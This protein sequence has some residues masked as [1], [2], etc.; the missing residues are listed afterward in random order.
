VFTDDTVRPEAAALL[1]P[2][3]ELRV[4]AAYPSE[5]TLALACRD[6]QGILARLGTVTRRVIEQAPRLKIIARH[7][8]GVDAVDLAAATAHG[9]V[10]TTTGAQ[11]AAAVAE[12]TVALMLAVLRHVPRAD[13]EM[14]SGAWARNALVGG[15]LDGRTLGVVG[16]GAIGRRVARAGCGF[17]MRVLAFDPALG[18][19][20]D[21]DA[22]LVG[23]ERLLA[24]A[25]VV[26]MHTRL[27]RDTER[28]M[29]ARAF[30]A[31]KPTAIFVN[32]ARGE[33]VDEPALVAALREGRIAGAALDTYAH[34]PLAPDSP[35][36]A[37]DNAVLSPHVAGQT[38]A[39]LTRVAICAAQSI[40]DE[41]AGRRPPYVHNPEVY[42]VRRRGA[43]PA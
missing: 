33:L 37:M 7:G 35:L 36:R 19:L 30:A 9:V 41:L 13:R 24:D 22:E 14:R 16:L 34:E 26:T 5:D 38:D 11:N 27:T 18:T 31:M 12:Y 21:A 2:H 3:C 8:V 25:D 29:G 20:T 10:V 40:L 1:A 4:L 23:F 28:M 43:L 32:T 42:A 17:G 6:A 15:E 39:A